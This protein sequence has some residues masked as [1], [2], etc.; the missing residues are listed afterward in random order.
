MG[1][2]APRWPV[3]PHVRG[4]AYSNTVEGYFAILT[5]GVYETFHHI[6]EAHLRRYLVE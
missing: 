4:D 2:V 6:S 3:V 5:R 1:R